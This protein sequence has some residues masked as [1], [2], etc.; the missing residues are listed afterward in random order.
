[1]PDRVI[2]AID[3]QRGQATGSGW[4]DEGKPLDEVLAP[5]ESFGITRALV[6]AIVRD[7]TMSGPDLVLIGTV[8]EAAPNLKITA[9]GGVGELSDLRALAM[10]GCEAVVVGRAL[11]ENRFTLE[12]AIA[13]AG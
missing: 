11:Y 12:Q 2:A 1:A 13:A 5:L 8:R 6:T 9:S 7:G 3:V 10:A 4:I